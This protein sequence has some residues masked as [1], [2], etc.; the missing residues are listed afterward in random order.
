MSN[1]SFPQ[2]LGVIPARSG[3]KGIPD[4]NL[5]DLA[6]RPLIAHTVEAA[7][8]SKLVSR[9]MVSTDDERIAAAARR[10]GAEVPFLRSG[11]LATDEATNVEVFID[12]I[13]RMRREG[14]AGPWAVLLQPTSPL[15]TAEDVDNCSRLMQERQAD[16]VVSVCEAEPH[17]WLAMQADDEDWLHPAGFEGRAQP[18]RQAFPPMYYLNGAI[19]LVEIDSFLKRRSMYG[20]RTTGYLMPRERSVD[21]NTPIDLQFCEF[22]LT[23]T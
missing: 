1:G 20:P 23:Q 5:V 14:F 8:A 12:A 15:R 3:S 9:L 4:K 7:R 11:E 17:P 13:E 18:G 10:A 6:G 19:Y 21:V 22:L 2:T 16:V